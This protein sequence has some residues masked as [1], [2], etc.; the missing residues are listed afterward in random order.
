[1]TGIKAGY[2]ERIIHV[3]IADQD[4]KGMFV[5]TLPN[6]GNKNII[7]KENVYDQKTQKPIG[8]VVYFTD[9]KKIEVCLLFGQKSNKFTMGEPGMVQQMELVPFVNAPVD[10][11]KL[12]RRKQYDYRKKCI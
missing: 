5:N 1:M 11:I 6:T 2:N 7:F 8:A 4:F 10:G 12:M 9:A 3:E